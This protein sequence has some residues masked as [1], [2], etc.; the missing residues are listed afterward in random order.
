MN[1]ITESK[2]EFSVGFIS[3]QRLRDN[4][5]AIIEFCKTK[6]EKDYLT[7]WEAIRLLQ[8]PEIQSSYS[9]KQ[10]IEVWNLENPT[11]D[12]G[13]LEIMDQ[14]KFQQDWSFTSSDIQR[15]RPNLEKGLELFSNFFP[16]TFKEFTN[17]IHSLLFA[18]R[19]AYDGGSVSSRIGMIWLSPKQTW[20]EVHWADNL[21]HEFVHNC[22]FIEDM[23]DTIFPFGAARMAKEDA[24]IISAIRRQKRGYDKSY[25]AAFVAYTLVEFY[26]TIGL[27]DKAIDIIPPLLVSLEDLSTNQNFISKNG[28]QYLDELIQN[29]LEKSN[30]LGIK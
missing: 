19:D 28:Q 17:I 30:E 21:V 15:L 3:P 13:L 27:I 16:E 4:Q 7:F 29:I 24:L 6:F 22:L 10:P 14:P 9:P 11:F 26:Q 18:K 23:V 25:H 1:T 20:T 8:S 2:T 12:K 5:S